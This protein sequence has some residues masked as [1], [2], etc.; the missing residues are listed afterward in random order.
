MKTILVP[1]DF[2]NATQ[3]VLDAAVAL[4][5]SVGGKIVVLHVIPPPVLTSGY[6]AMLDNVSEIMAANEKSTKVRLLA[7]KAD[8]KKRRIPTK[9]VFAFGMPASVILEEAKATEPAYIILGSHGHTA[10]Y[11][12]L[13]GSTTHVVLKNATCPVVVVPLAKTPKAKKAR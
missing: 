9:T 6:G 12:L 8:F 7:I 13:V 5:G 1:V 2:S 11:D 4:R 10:V 3:A